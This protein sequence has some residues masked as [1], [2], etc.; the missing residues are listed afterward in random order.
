MTSG[1]NPNDLTRWQAW[2]RAA[3]PRTLTATYV[4]LGAAGVIA[5]QDGVFNLVLFVLSLIAAL[6]LQ[7]AAN[8]INEYYDY[9]RGAEDL[10]QAGQGMI[11]KQGLLTPR[12]VL[13][14]A[15]ATVLGGIA[16]GLFLLFQ[17]GPLLFWIGLGGVLVVLAYTAG[18]F[19]LAYNGLGEVA[20][21]IFMGPLMVLGAYYV[22]AEQAS[23]VPVL[24]GIPIGSMCAAILDA[25]NVRDVDADRA[26]N[27][28]TLAVLLGQH[29]ARWEYAILVVGAYVLLAL[30]VVLGVVPWPTLLVVVTL[31]QAWK[32]V[33]VVMTSNDTA[34][35]HRAQGGT[36][37]LHGRFGLWLVVGWLAALLLAGLSS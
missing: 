20:V 24:I 31:P 18:P 4:P 21:G 27:K 23:W 6:L 33:Q 37:K 17:S 35:L 30:L 5:L 34:L 19:P 2:Y 16:I 14:G 29:A 22:M 28:R 10:K 26:V 1:S 25:N 12:E 32:L 15:I 3:R 11:L 7:I 36:A 13:A 8:L 9:R